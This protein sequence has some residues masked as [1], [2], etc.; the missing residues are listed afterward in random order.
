[1][2]KKNTLPP[3]VI[4][5]ETNK[6]SKFNKINLFFVL[7]V[8]VVYVFI[9]IITPHTIN[10]ENLNQLNLFLDK[11][12]FGCFLPEISDKFSF[13]MKV[14]WCFSW[15]I[16]LLIFIT[17]L[18][19]FLISFKKEEIL[20][21]YNQFCSS[22]LNNKKNKLFFHLKYIFIGFGLIGLFFYGNI[23]PYTYLGYGKEHSLFYQNLYPSFII[24]LIGNMGIYHFIV[25]V[26]SNI[27]FIF[28]EV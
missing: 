9:F 18:M 27:N 24:F 16:N 13:K 1:M 6:T 17:L 23:G 12:L 25:L 4:K 20:S 28:L 26:V 7:F 14:V 21:I 10:S 11:Y 5:L 3:Y 8:I 22:L 2:N 15:V 19:V